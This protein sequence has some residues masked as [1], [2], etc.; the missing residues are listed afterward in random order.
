M[1]RSEGVM[2]KTISRRNGS[3]KQIVFGD[4]EP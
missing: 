1:R 4:H 2:T 3:V